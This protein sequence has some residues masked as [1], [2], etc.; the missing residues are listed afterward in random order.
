MNNNRILQLDDNLFYLDINYYNFNLNI[1]HNSTLKNYVFKITH[2]ESDNITNK[3]TK[4]FNLND[5]EKIINNH[6]FFNIIKSNPLLILDNI[7]NNYFTI[8]THFNT[9]NLLI[10]IIDYN[11][12][13]IIFNF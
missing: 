13:E 3:Y 7:Q 12:K 2:Y 5:I 6:N 10:K 11:N 1:I 8:Y 9:V 4:T